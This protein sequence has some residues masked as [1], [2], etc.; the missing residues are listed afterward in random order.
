MAGKRPIYVPDKH[1]EKEI[2]Q[3]TVC[4]NSYFLL[5]HLDNE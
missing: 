1:F 5:S 3:S 4:G 2:R